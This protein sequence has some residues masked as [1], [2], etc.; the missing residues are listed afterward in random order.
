MLKLII[1]NDYKADKDILTQSERE[2]TIAEILLTNGFLDNKN[3]ICFNTGF[4]LITQ[5]LN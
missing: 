1:N 3:V 2:E 5:I 4:K